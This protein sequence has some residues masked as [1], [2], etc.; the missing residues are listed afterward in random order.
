[1]RNLQIFAEKMHSHLHLLIILFKNKIFHRSELPRERAA[2]YK[3][4]L[5]CQRALQEALQG[6]FHCSNT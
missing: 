1:M 5:A 6:L 3:C 2:G 4:G